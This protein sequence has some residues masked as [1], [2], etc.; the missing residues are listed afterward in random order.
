MIELLAPAQ[1]SSFIFHTLNGIYY[2]FILF[3][4]AAGLTVILGVMGVLNLT[5]GELYSFGAYTA[6][7]VY[8]F[9]VATIAPAPV[10]I[11]S[12]LIF[13]GFMLVAAALAALVLVPFG[14]ILESVFI[15]PVYGRHE[16]YELLLTFALLLIIID[17]IKA[18]WGE[19]PIRADGVYSG[20]NEIPTTEMVGLTYPSYNIVAMVIG[21]IV[22]G[23]LIWFFDRTKT[24]RIIRATAINREMAT[25]SGINTDRM[26]TL[27]FALGAFLAG[28]G[29]AMAVPPMAT[30]LE[31]GVYPLILSFV[32]IVIGGLGSIPGAFVAALL[33]GVTSRWATWLYPPVELAAPF[34]LMAI[35]LLIKPEGLFGTWGELE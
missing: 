34:A 12:A 11:T 24:G 5:H 27:V 26:F 2:G 17:V 6:V 21:L 23:L 8:G 31:M 22:F 13:L 35:V 9:F 25:A 10:D 29:G 30:S 28:V 1:L 16:A 4:I 18:I 14:T 33:V 3:M 20:I 7:S 19:V 15:R 32:I